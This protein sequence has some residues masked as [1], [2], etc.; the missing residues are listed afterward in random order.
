VGVRRRVMSTLVVAGAL[1]ISGCTGGGPGPEPSAS[2]TVEPSV[3]ASPTPSDPGVAKPERP[4]DMDRT[5]E[6]GA[7]AAAEYFLELYPYI[8]RT[9]DFT[10]WDALS[11]VN[12]EYCADSRATAVELRDGDFLLTDADVEARVVA[13][14]QLDQNFNAYPVD[15]IT[16]QF[17][18]LILDASSVQVG[19]VDEEQIETR[20]DVRHNGGDWKVIAVAKMG[21]SP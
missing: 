2:T 15:L 10:E 21:V 5:D 16:H 9:G 20:V 7:A 1:A 12:C 19:V 6:A 4:A 11:W 14:H 13:V 17:P 8:M 18:G 3:T